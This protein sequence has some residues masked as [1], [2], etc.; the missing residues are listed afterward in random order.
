MAIVSIIGPKGGIGKTTL[1]INVSAALTRALNSEGRVCLLD[2]DLR[3]PTISD[4]LNSHPR[5]TFYDLF[6]TL[7]N[8]TY[9]I[10]FLQTLYRILVTFRDRLSGEIAD[11]SRKL[12]KSLALYQNLN[13]DLFH[14][15]SFEFGDEMHELFL[16]RSDIRTAADLNLLKPMFDRLDIE[17]FHET[18]I[19]Y[20]E[21]SKPVPEEYVHFVEEYGFAIM[22]GEVPILGKKSH[23]KRIHEPAF[24]VFFLEFLDEIFK[25]FEYVVLDTPAGGVGHLSSLMNAIDQVLLVFDMSNRIAIEGSIDALH[26]FIDYY[27]DFYENYRQGRLH[28][29]DKAYVNRLVAARGREAVEDAI[30]NKTLGLLFNRCG[31]TNEIA[32][33]LDRIR[34]YLDTL[35]QYGK[36]KDKIHIVGMMPQ[37]RIIN[38]TNN[39]GALFY[40]KDRTLAGNLNQ[41]ASG[42]LNRNQQCPTLANSNAEIIDA[43]K[44][45]GKAGIAAGIKRLANVFN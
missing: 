15:S 10:D 2:L 17:K 3:L 25:R 23:R 45:N 18:L 28:G 5:K 16:H 13:P 26:S 19:H 22:G 40:D 9:Q 8:K 31:E 42:I 24:L 39:R 38:I 20:Q 35:N 6:E 27:E 4:I 34:E 30:D 7:A 14:F 41:I 11:D 12:W 32:A 44:P 37:N 29:L 33:C 21:N 43:L 36:Y 1:S